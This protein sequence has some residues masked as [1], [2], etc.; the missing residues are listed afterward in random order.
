MPVKILAS[1][2]VKWVIGYP[3]MELTGEDL[4]SGCILFSRN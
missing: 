2:N 3:R 1:G 4:G